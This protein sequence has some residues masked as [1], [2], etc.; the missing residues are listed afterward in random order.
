MSDLL[1]LGFFNLEGSG[2]VYGNVLGRIM[3]H[4][5]IYAKVTN[6][7][8]LYIHE[9]EVPSHVKPIYCSKRKKPPH[10]LKIRFNDVFLFLT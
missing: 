2:D 10:K 7:P 9:H 8:F 3:Q 4:A 1:I 5:T 6:H